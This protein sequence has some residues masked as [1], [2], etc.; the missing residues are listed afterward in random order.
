MHLR[1]LRLR[2]V[3]P[4]LIPFHRDLLTGAR[5]RIHISVPRLLHAYRAVGSA[6][7]AS[8]SAREL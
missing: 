1:E 3:T 7:L 2:D 6:A 4:A 5:T 8:D